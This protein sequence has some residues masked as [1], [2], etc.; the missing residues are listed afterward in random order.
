M[1]KFAPPL[2]LL[3]LTACSNHESGNRLLNADSEAANWL[4]HGR[5]YDE[6]RFSPLDTI[7][8][9]NVSELG[10][11]WSFDM[12]T[13]HGVEATPLVV[14]GI[15]YVTS[16]W[17][18]VYALDAKTG[19]L[20]WE[21]DPQADRG[22]T[23][24]NS[25]CDVVNRGVAWW[26]GKIFLGV[27]DGRLIALD[28][29]TG[30]VVW[31]TQTTD[32]AEPYTI[33]G[34]PRVV[35][36]KV[37]IGNGGADLG[38]RG[39]ISAY[40]ADN[41]D[42]VWRF[43]T[44]PGDPQDGFENK[45]LEE[46]AKTW[47]GEWWKWGG[48]GTVW[49]SMAYDPELD[50][51]YFGVGNGSPWNYELRSNGE[52]DNLFLSSIVAV[53]PDSGEY[54]WHYQTTPG[55]SW[56]FT[57]TQHMVLADLEIDGVVRKVLMQAPKNGFFY[58]L[59]R[60]TGELLS[61]RNYTDVNWATHINTQTGRPVE[62]DG[63]RDFSEPVT[64]LPGAGGG[65]N[66]PP[67]SYNPEEG[68]VYIPTQQFAWVYL[69]PNTVNDSEPGMG[70]WN[71]GINTLALA[72]P[73]QPGIRAALREMYSSSLLAWDP[74]KQEAVWKVDHKDVSAGGILSTAGDLVFQ[75]DPQGNL[76]AYNSKTGNKLWSHW[77]QT[78]GMAAP[79]TY[80]V[81]DKQYVAIAVGWGGGYGVMIGGL[82][83]QY[84]LKS[85]PRVLVYELG[86]TA[87]LPAVEV[88]PFVIPEPAP[89]T[90]DEA[91]VQRGMVL[92][93]RQCM[94]CHGDRAVSGNVVP[95]LRTSDDDVHLLWHGIVVGGALNDKGMASFAEF[96]NIDESE[97]I[98]QYVLMEAGKSYR[99]Q[100]A[101][102]Q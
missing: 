61:A 91:T 23:A 27:I 41:G 68:L 40:D 52:G 19:E 81:D 86:G 62:V 56:D 100:E 82:T 70:K 77:I 32:P 48:G 64:M 35:K 39:Y 87:T 50:L 12:S 21:F 31:Q 96:I 8:T 97:A 5:T 7:N 47:N 10:L 73:D 15:M 83:K 4:S 74:V 92:Y 88:E 22:K 1:L 3:L 59:D 94:W 85:R 89:V 16:S 102:S 46:A 55:E 72:F 13:D 6:Q 99:E 45:A 30:D 53:R 76:S 20:I 75:A 42:M 66:W 95:D 71:L 54:V 60:E 69:A 80:S 37:L 36:G 9:R 79:M 26:D 49:D 65:H 101:Q 25:C 43:Y 11:S 18:L 67:M 78:G 14:D 51:L 57:A 33:T 24:A 29:G 28:A 2:L 34:A 90:A 38:V 17:S 58:V 98:R 84:G 93:H 44:V 63:I